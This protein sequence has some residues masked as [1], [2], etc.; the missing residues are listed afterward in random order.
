M[1]T[2]E[3]TTVVGV[4]IDPIHAKQAAEQL[5]RAGLREEQIV[6]VAR[7]ETGL[8]A[9]LSEEDALYYQN[10]L[11]LGYTIITVQ[12][13]DQ[14]ADVEHL[15]VENGAYHPGQPLTILHKNSVPTYPDDHGIQSAWVP[16]G[17]H[18]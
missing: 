2:T 9:G 8:I 16:Y 18:R 17:T 6:F 12:A 13:D 10:A 11:T 7:H 4:F 3:R 15:F 1:Q 14:A 5:R